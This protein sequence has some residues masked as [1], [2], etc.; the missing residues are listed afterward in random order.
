MHNKVFETKEDYEKHC[1]S[2]IY[3]CP[4]CE[5]MF[6]KINQINNHIIICKNQHLIKC[7]NCD[8][9]FKN[10]ESMSAHFYEA[11]EKKEEEKDKYK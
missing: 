9:K 2:H 7:T 10:I 8:L 5:M 4:Y 3:K 1:K 11:H 6:D